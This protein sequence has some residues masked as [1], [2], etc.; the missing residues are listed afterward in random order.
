MGNIIL[1]TLPLKK[2]PEI[3]TYLNTDQT[4]MPKKFSMTNTRDFLVQIARLINRFFPRDK[5]V[6]F[7]QAKVA[8]RNMSLSTMCKLYSITM[9][10]VVLKIRHIL[11][12][13][14]KD[15]ALADNKKF[16]ER[17]ASVMDDL[18]FAEHVLQ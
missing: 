2:R 10:K 14:D 3:G 18:K 11:E 15:G 13:L 6:S 7:A 8:H 12:N 5:A 4:G 1:G 9:N 16:K 17:C